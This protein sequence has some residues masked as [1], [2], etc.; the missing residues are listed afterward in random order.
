MEDL[1][2]ETSSLNSSFGDLGL[3]EEEKMNYLM[4]AFNAFTKYDLD[5]VGLISGSDFRKAMSEAGLKFGTK[6]VDAILRLITFTPDGKI[7]FLRMGDV[8]DNLVARSANRS[9]QFANVILQLGE[10]DQHH[11]RGFLHRA[12][13]IPVPRGVTTR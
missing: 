3:N 4:A 8:V 11:P 6:E 7:D 2:D 5:H 9:L 10:T 1:R 13:A 12:P